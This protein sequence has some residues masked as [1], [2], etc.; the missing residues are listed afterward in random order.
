MAEFFLVVTDLQ[1]TYSLVRGADD[2]FLPLP[3]HHW[4]RSLALEL[5]PGWTLG[6]LRPH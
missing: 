2:Y 6:R 1:V 5:Y 4:P 3:L